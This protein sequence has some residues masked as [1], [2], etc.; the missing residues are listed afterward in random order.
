MRLL[1]T[2]LPL[3]LIQHG[4]EHAVLFDGYWN[5]QIGLACDLIHQLDGAPPFGGEWYDNG[6]FKGVLYGVR[7][8]H[9]ALMIMLQY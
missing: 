6:E 3:L 7:S 1:K 4:F 5:A 8:E 9:T 2:D